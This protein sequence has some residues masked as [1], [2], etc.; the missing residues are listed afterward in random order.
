MQ[1][2]LH[3]GEFHKKDSPYRQWDPQPT[4]TDQAM[5]IPLPPP[6]GNHLWDRLDESPFE[7]A[8]GFSGRVRV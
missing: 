6:Q 8:P 7:S 2:R 1:Q 3:S 4:R 5:R